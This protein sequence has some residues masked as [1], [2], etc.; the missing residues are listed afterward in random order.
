[1]DA[2]RV[3]RI[4]SQPVPR[5]NPTARSRTNRPLGSVRLPLAGPY[6]PRA[7]LYRLGDGRLLWTVR[8]WEYDRAVHHVVSTGVLLRFAR[9]NGLAAVER[10][11]AEVVRAAT[12]GRS[13]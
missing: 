4:P 10:E 5:T 12:E 9:L 8:L 2:K 6:R 7:T 1:M 13:R 3:D 11:V